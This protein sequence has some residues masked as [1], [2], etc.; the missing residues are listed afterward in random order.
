MYMYIYIYIYIY[1]N[2]RMYMYTNL[3]VSGIMSRLPY[4]CPILGKCKCQKSLK[5]GA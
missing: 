3:P 1:I 4:P 2:L 5:P